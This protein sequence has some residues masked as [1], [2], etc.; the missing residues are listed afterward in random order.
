[1]MDLL[2]RRFCLLLLRGGGGGAPLEAAVKQDKQWLT[3]YLHVL[4]V[5]YNDRISV[6]G[7][8]NLQQMLY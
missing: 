3:V 8:Y 6:R 7:R 1:M 4:A 2:V 5:F